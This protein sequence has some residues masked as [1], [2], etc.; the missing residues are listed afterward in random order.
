[1]H[2]FFND[3][4][5][6]IVDIKLDKLDNIPITNTFRLAHH[7]PKFKVITLF[8]NSLHHYATI[9]QATLSLFQ[10]K[11]ELR[12]NSSYSI[13]KDTLKSSGLIGQENLNML[14]L[15]KPYYFYL[16]TGEHNG[17]KQCTLQG[18]RQDIFKIKN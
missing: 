16:L 7:T 17:K 5:E 13:P 14:D 11:M 3:T 1:M 4:V 2:E 18:T 6:P 15:T 9:T 10:F 8:H 12:K